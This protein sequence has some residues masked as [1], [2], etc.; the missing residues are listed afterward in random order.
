M[1]KKFEIEF[2][3]MDGKVFPVVEIIGNIVDDKVIA[4]LGVIKDLTSILNIDNNT[5]NE[6]A[7]FLYENAK[8]DINYIGIQAI[9]L[10]K[11]VGPRELLKSNKKMRKILDDLIDLYQKSLRGCISS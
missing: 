10:S 9:L 3:L 11:N 6:L 4:E 8:K 1:N 2:R 5:L 7:N